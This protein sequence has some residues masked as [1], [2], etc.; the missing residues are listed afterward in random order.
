[1]KNTKKLTLRCLCE[2]AVMVALAQILGYLK[3]YELPQGGSVTPAMLPL[4]VFC[5][6][7]GFAPGLAACTLFGLLQ[8]LLDGAYTWGW[9]SIFFDY[10][11]AFG[12]LGTAGLCRG[13]RGNLL[14]GSVVGCCARFLSH[15]VSGVLFVRGTAELEIY[16]VKTASA[17]V[18]SALYNGAYML[19]T[20]VL[21][22]LLGA[23]LLRPL[24]TFLRAEDLRR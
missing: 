2:G 21:T 11:I 18:Y 24:R 12:V 15:L 7:W 8:L 1:M 9:I 5:V 22:V 13:C 19:P 17:W 23:L 6:R 4:M 14:I 16:G 3:L 10:L 20:M